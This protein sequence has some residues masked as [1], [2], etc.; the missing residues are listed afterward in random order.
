MNKPIPAGACAHG[1]RDPPMTMTTLPPGA[2][3]LI[4]EGQR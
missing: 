2:D 3:D 4:L 1:R